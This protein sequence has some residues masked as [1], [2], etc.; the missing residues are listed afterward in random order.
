MVTHGAQHGLACVLR[1]IARPGEAVLTE[2]LSYPG[3]QSLARSMRLQ[4][5]GIETDQEGMTP[6]SLERAAKTFDTKFVYCAPTL[7]NPTCA[8]MSVQRREEIAAV[9]RAHGLYVIEDCVHAAIQANPLPALST[10][11][12]EQSFLL[13]SFS[14]V[15]APGLRV[16]YIEAAPTW[17]SKFAASM[18][19]DSWMVAPLLP[20]IA[21]RW[22]ETGEMETLIA[23]QRKQT[24]ER[25]AIAHKILRGVEF[26][27][28]P[29]FPLIW[30][31]LPEPWRAGQFAGALRQAGVLVRTAD[32]FGVGRSPAPQSVRISLNAPANIE[33]LEKGL[34]IFKSVIDN[35]PV[36]FM[37]RTSW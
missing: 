37:G 18:R 15:L 11:L 8:T 26:K 3:L 25:L 10:W 7:H 28:D 34:Q 32:H 1:T 5:I 35:P 19:A 2:S 29:E 23:Q 9:V 33:L 31:P 16:G 14:K 4:L 22:I 13:S 24:T 12:P 21:T 27:T 6:A 30:V 17:L 36:I 20:E